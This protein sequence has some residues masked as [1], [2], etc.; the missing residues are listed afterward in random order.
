MIPGKE[1]TCLMNFIKIQKQIF[2]AVMAVHNKKSTSIYKRTLY[3][4]IYISNRC[5]TLYSHGNKVNIYIYIHTHSYISWNFLDVCTFEA[6]KIVKG[7]SQKALEGYKEI[8]NATLSDNRIRPEDGDL[9]V[10]QVLEIFRSL[11]GLQLVY[12]CIIQTHVVEDSSETAS[13]VTMGP[14]F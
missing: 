5:S 2:E 14:C 7:A 9:M 3:L 12:V 6:S 1:K 11:L 10:L 13:I 8:L 4:N